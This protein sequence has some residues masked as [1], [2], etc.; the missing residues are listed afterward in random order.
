MYSVIIVIWSCIVCRASYGNEFFFLKKLIKSQNP[1]MPKERRQDLYS[2]QGHS[3]TWKRY[4][5]YKGKH[6]KKKH[7]KKIVKS[8]TLINKI[9]L[10]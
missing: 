10:S 9:K 5:R 1:R 8:E 2:I 3:M 6:I 4:H 7:Y